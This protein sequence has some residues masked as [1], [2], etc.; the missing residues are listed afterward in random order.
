[1]AEEVTAFAVVAV[2]KFDPCSYLDAALTDRRSRP[3]KIGHQGTHLNEDGLIFKQLS[4]LKKSLISDALLEQGQAYFSK[5][6]FHHT[7]P[8]ANNI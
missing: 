7:S 4:V 1:M 5:H 3:L 8:A 6:L 2:V